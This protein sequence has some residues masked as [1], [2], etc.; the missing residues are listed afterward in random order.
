MAKC[1]QQCMLQLS[2]VGWLLHKGCMVSRVVCD[3]CVRGQVAAWY[4]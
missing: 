4:T 1:L 3:L 2:L